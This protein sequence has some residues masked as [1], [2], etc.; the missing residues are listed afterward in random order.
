MRLS[1]V[2]RQLSKAVR[3]LALG[4]D[5]VPAILFIGFHYQPVFSIYGVLL[6]GDDKA[7]ADE[8]QDILCWKAI[9]YIEPKGGGR[10]RTT[11]LDIG[12]DKTYSLNVN[13]EAESVRWV[14]PDPFTEILIRQLRR[15]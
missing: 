15:W 9:V 13:R 12:G 7:I 1:P 11:L 2:D 14:K 4:H 3:R 8:F 10:N 5:P 6:S